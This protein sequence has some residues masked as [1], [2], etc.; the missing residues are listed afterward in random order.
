[1][2]INHPGMLKNYFKV[3]LRNLWKSKGF[4]LINIL[5]LAA[6][7]AVCLMIVLYVTDEL[8]Y[9]RNNDKAGRIYRLDAEIY[10]NNT[11]FNSATSPKPLPITLVKEC[12]QV[13]QMARVSFFNSQS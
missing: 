6:G 3:A 5:G 1:M 9:D 8:S 4:T 12:P 7:L 13:E 10:F 11:L 2:P